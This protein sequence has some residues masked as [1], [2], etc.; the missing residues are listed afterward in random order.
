[1]PSVADGREMF[2]NR[3]QRAVLAATTTTSTGTG[4]GRL[5]FLAESRATR[6]TEE[7]RDARAKLRAHFSKAKNDDG[8]EFAAD[9]VDAEE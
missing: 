6:N 1:M 8:S 9:Y 3:R 4:R 2:D 7:G 5:A